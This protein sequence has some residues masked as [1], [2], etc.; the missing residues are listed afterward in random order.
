MLLEK[1]YVSMVTLKN[2][3]VNLKKKVK[4]ERKSFS[5]LWSGKWYRYVLSF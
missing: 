2:F 4:N 1:I 5:F 3:M